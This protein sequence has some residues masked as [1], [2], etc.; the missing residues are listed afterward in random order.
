M[1]RIVVVEDDVNTLELV[2]RYFIN[3]GFEVQGFHSTYGVLAYIKQHHI[4][5]CVLDVMIGHSNGFDLLKEIKA[6]KDIPIIFVT[7]KADEFDR[8]YGIEIGGDDYMTKPFSPRELVARAKR[9]LK[10]AY[11]QPSD[12]KTEVL[13]IGRIEVNTMTMVVKDLE[14]VV[15]LTLK[16]YELLVYMMRNTNRVLPRDTIIEKVWGYDALGQTRMVDDI[17]KRLRKKLDVN[18]E[19][20]W[21]VGYRLYE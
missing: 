13:K 16:E 10:R 3:E 7:A 11:E 2:K 4:D 9:L 14:T 17:V 18:I 19:T 21:G 5:M 15:T 20:V 8:I 6:Y 12:T 1:T